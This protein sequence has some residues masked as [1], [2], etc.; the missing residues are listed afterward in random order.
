MSIE[1]ENKYPLISIQ[2]N[3]C[4]S[5]TY[6][7]YSSTEQN[8]HIHLFVFVFSH[9]ATVKQFFS[10]SIF[11]QVPPVVPLSTPRGTRTPI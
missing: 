9:S 2:Y 10:Y 5:Q 6:L 4:I 11:S 7:V 1:N 8:V 3:S